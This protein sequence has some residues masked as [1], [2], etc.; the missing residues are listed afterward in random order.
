MQTIIT[1][2]R[3]TSHYHVRTK[4]GR[5]SG[6]E[7]TALQTLRADRTPQTRAKR[8]DCGAFTAALLA[9]VILGLLFIAVPSSAAVKEKKSTLA[10]ANA[11]TIF[12]PVPAEH[13]LASVWN[14]PDF[15]RRLIG[16]Y[17]FASDVE[18][19]MQPAELENYRKVVV[20]ALTNSDP[21]KVISTL[22]GLTGPRASAV[23]DF[24]LGNVYFQREDLTNAVKHFEAAITKEPDYRRAQKNLA[25]ALV[26]DG[27]YPEAIKPLTRTIALGGADGKVFGLLGYAYLSQ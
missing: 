14:D 15:Q 23:F 9:P 1:D 22:E 26:R 7:A 5:E 24:T 13:E 19:K 25:F 17:G 10:A 4:L 18:P 3:R 2:R 11:P 8:L 20:P 6:A 27:K 21:K 16:S 12:A